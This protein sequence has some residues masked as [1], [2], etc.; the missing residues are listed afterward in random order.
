VEHIRY[1]LVRQSHGGMSESWFGAGD[2]IINAA[3]RK[4]GTIDCGAMLCYC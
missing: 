2:E 4:Y 3:S 1:V